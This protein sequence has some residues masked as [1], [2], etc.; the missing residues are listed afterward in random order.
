MLG[1]TLMGKKIF[2]TSDGFSFHT[3]E[4]RWNP[5]DAAFANAFDRLRQCSFGSEFY[6]VKE[7][8]GIFAWRAMR[9]QEMGFG[10]S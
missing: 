7:S 4:L 10:C 2:L 6:P 3:L 8:G 9:F 1:A 5:T